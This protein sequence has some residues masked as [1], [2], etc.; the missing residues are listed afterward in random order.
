VKGTLL[1]L[2]VFYD[3]MPSIEGLD[4]W[5]VIIEKKDDDPSD[6]DVLRIKVS[7][8]EGQDGKQLEERIRKS[9]NDAVE[10]NPVVEADHSS[11]ELFE[12]MGGKLKV[13]RIV[14]LR[15]GN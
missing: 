9:V 10:I 14:D 8:M 11:D 13:R 5:Q 12:Q 2:N 1:N 7:P 4:E 6:L 3:I 15:E